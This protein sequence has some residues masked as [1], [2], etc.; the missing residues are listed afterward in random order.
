V[1]LAVGN[2]RML[3]LHV[4]RKAPPPYRDIHNHVSA[5]SSFVFAGTLIE[6]RYALDGTTGDHPH[7][8]GRTHYH[9]P[10]WRTVDRQPKRIGRADL[11]LLDVASHREGSL[12]EI[13]PDAL[14]DACPDESSLPVMTLVAQD[15]AVREW[16]D[17]FTTGT[18]AES[19][20]LDPAFDPLALRELLESVTGQVRAS[21]RS[22]RR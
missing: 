17:V 9:Y 1:L 7:S 5:L 8:L 11:R 18:I 4:W 20:D 19:Q 12:Y 2:D 14:H 13:P 21:Q 16:T 22:G 15:S 10:S 3:R 6:S